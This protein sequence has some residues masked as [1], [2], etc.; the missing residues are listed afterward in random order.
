M[1]TRY[2]VV[3]ATAFVLLA[4][5]VTAAVAR[6]DPV[7]GLPSSMAST[8]DS[9][10]RA[11]DL[12]LFHVLVDTPQDSWSTGADPAVDSQYQRIRRANPGIGAG[13]HNDARTS[14][15]MADLDGQVTAAAAQRVQY[16]TVLMGANDLCTASA[17]TMTPTAVFE[18]QFSRAMADFFRLDPAAHVLVSSIPDLFQL[19]STLHTNPVAA[20]TWGVAH[21]CQSM[22][23]ITDTGVQ[24]RQV[25][26][27]E[28]ADNAVLG[29]VCR[30]YANCRWDGNAVYRVRFTPADVGNFDYFHP[31][32]MGQKALASVTWRAG[33][34]PAITPG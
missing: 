10:T 13:V 8:G 11:F 6:T 28:L 22:L 25:V 16:L 24:R 31:S 1:R 12:D 3:L 29:S 32:L 9:I 33:F 17:A 4:A 26:Q 30:R 14:A 19:W 7:V 21:I 2:W 27:Q 5:G 23:A 20:A 34:W 18:A 15:R